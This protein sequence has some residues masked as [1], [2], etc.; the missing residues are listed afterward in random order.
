MKWTVEDFEEVKSLDVEVN[1]VLH[2]FWKAIDAIQKKVDESTEQES[3]VIDGDLES[4][5]EDKIRGDIFK[6]VHRV[7]RADEATDQLYKLFTQY[8]NQSKHNLA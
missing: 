7:K 1:H 3:N 2:L 8:A 4:A 6:I 5:A